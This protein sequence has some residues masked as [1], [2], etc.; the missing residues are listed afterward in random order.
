[1]SGRLLPFRRSRP[2]AAERGTAAFSSGPRETHRADPAGVA[3]P[4]PRPSGAPRFRE[5]IEP[6]IDAAYSLARYLARDATAAEDIAQEA[7]LKAFRNIDN[8]RGEVRPWL[9]AIVRNT[10]F[11]WR[12]RDG[13]RLVVGPAA[14]VAMAQTPDDG[15]PSA[16][17]ALI[18]QGDV[19]GLRAAI[20]AI[21]EPF[22]EALVLRD[23]EELSYRD[24]A[25]ITG[26]P[27][28]TVMSRLARARRMLGERMGVLEATV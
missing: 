15:T 21:P 11:D 16:E 20:D 18:Q 27:M 14:D 5:L 13:G 4:F 8:V 7:L 23:L 19:A 6:H 26:V 2:R 24:V 1:M 17:A 28:G 12:R 3:A 9:L 10:Y 22:R 25:E